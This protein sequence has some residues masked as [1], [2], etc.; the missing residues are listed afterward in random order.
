MFWEKR[1]YLRQ[2]RSWLCL[3]NA[4]AEARSWKLGNCGKNDRRDGLEQI[5][6]CCDDTTAADE[7][8]STGA[9]CSE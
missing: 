5:S 1:A 6:R 2:E 9:W 3:P 4:D 7:G 8:Y